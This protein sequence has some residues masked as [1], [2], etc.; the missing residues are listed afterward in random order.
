VGSLQI[1]RTGTIGGN[2]GN[3]S[4]A[5]DGVAALTALG[6]VALVASP[7]GQRRLPLIELI[8]A[9]YKT[10][11]AHDEIIVGYFLDRLPAGSS[12]VF[13]K[14]GRRRAVAVSRLNL[15]VCL[16]PEMSEPRVVLGSCFPTPRRLNEVEALLTAG[17]PG[18]ELWRQ[19]GQLAAD[20]FV[21]VCGWRSSANYKVPAIRAMLARTL[22]Q[23]WQGLDQAA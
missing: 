17:R 16:E 19:A 15:A 11:L 7:R 10:D 12:Q 4:P 21:Q 14:A 18:P 3:G 9:P 2:A 20:T 13:S 6:A 1:R 23:A 8:T 22:E 5:A